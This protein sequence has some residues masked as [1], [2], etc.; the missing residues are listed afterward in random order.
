MLHHLS[1][2]HKADELPF[3]E[4]NYA[5]WHIVSHVNDSYRFI[6]WCERLICKKGVVDDPR[7]RHWRLW[8]LKY[9]LS[10]LS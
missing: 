10:H 8:V 3:T 4:I 9:F 6:L 2:I 5:L 1:M 7:L